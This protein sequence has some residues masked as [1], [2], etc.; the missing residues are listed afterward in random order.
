MYNLHNP[1]L[2][3][4]RHGSVLRCECC[5]RIQITFRGHV[6]LVDE[7]EFELLLQT[8]QHAWTQLREAEGT[9]QWRLQAETDGGEVGVVLTE[10]SLTA[11]HELLQGAWAMYVLR[12]RV[13]AAA[14]GLSGRAPDVLRDH[15]PNAT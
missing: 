6:L 4:T 5:T 3:E 15:V 11:L 9:D 2:F 1:D 14:T 13:A 8:V 7:D 10:P 12:E